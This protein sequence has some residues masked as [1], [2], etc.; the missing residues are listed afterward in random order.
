MGEND[1]AS[2]RYD[3]YASPPNISLAKH[4]LLTS[5]VYIPKHDKDQM[6]YSKEDP[7]KPCKCILCE[8]Q[9][10]YKEKNIHYSTQTANDK[11]KSSENDDRIEGFNDIEKVKDF[12]AGYYL[13]YRMNRMV[14]F[15]G[16][17]LFLFCLYPIIRNASKGS[18]V[19]SDAATVYAM[20]AT[21]PACKSS[22][23]NFTSLANFNVLAWD[24]LERGLMIASMVL[25]MLISC[26]WK[27]LIDLVT[28]N[29]E[30]NV[31][32]IEDFSVL[33][34]NIAPKHMHRIYLFD[35]DSVIYD[36]D[37]YV[38]EI[39]SN[40]KIRDKAK[41]QQTKPMQSKETT[42][43][44][45]A[46][47][48]RRRSQNAIAPLV[49][50][51]GNSASSSL[52]LRNRTRLQDEE[53]LQKVKPSS[54]AS[55]SA[56]KPNEESSDKGYYKVYSTNYVYK[57]NQLVALDKELTEYKKNLR[58][59]LDKEPEKDAFEIPEAIKKIFLPQLNKRVLFGMDQDW[60]EATKAYSNNIVSIEL[61][62]FSLKFQIDFIKASF[63]SRKLLNTMDEI[64]D[65]QTSYNLGEV[66]VTFETNTMAKQFKKQFKSLSD[67][68]DEDSLLRGNIVGDAILLAK[69][70]KH[71]T[72]K[73]VQVCRAPKPTDIIWANVGTPL[74]SRVLWTGLSFL[75]T[76][77]AL[78]VSF[79]IS[80]G[81]EFAKQSVEDKSAW[82]NLLVTGIAG[83]VN[84][85]TGIAL[86]M[87]IEKFNAMEDHKLHSSLLDSLMIKVTLV[88][89]SDCRLS[90]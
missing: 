39:V 36:L 7:Y 23:F 67:D 69:Y 22:Y 30:D 54:E 21:L 57:S 81:F 77:L 51:P 88:G 9:F 28:K 29:L 1:V 10:S 85:A 72:T 55:S 33:L 49:S 82:L 24:G 64:L 58:K 65:G 17:M 60:I 53:I 61:D 4:H 8:N 75:F 15:I 89:A 59:Q 74:K 32:G 31:D 50:D 79:G 2:T 27:V 34:K 46:V 78:T 3:P 87:L 43:A 45:Y 44:V 37:D 66:Y 68:L 35:E 83:I 5:S 80:V 42:Q 16:F 70:L 62:K 48:A 18:C 41:G 76:I 63:I 47:D 40:I 86:D 90:S 14:I 71:A 25:L 19:T 11:A 20:S 13:L 26:L 38:K 56:P 6:K 84:F 52:L 73:Q 12:G